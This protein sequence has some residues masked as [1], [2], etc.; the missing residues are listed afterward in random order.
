MAESKINITFG[1]DDASKEKISDLTRFTG[2][3]ESLTETIKTLSGRLNELEKATTE[4]IGPTTIKEARVSAD[5]S[6]LYIALSPKSEWPKQP[7]KITNAGITFG[8]KGIFSCGDTVNYHGI[9]FVIKGRYCTHIALTAANNL[10]IQFLFKF[11]YIT[12]V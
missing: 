1:D 9:D 3:I 5:K 11:G 4:S 12:N 7:P 8:G 2:V 10:L 6:A